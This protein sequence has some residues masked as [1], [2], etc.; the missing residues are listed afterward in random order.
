MAVADLPWTK[1]GLPEL[2]RKALSDL[3][4]FEREYPDMA[5]FVLSYPWVA[6]GIT[7]DEQLALHYLLV[8]T[9][10]SPWQNSLTARCQAINTA[11]S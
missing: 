10:G 4:T 8:I 9:Q 7:E 5:E 3:Q 11:R 6:D 1:E 2:E